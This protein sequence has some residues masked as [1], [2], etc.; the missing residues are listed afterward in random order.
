MQEKH[1]RYTKDYSSR[2]R[3]KN[4]NRHLISAD[5]AEML[6]FNIR[7]SSRSNPLRIYVS[8]GTYNSTEISNINFHSMKTS[9]YQTPNTTGQVTFGGGDV[10]VITNIPLIQFDDASTTFDSSIALIDSSFV[11]VGD[12]IDLLLILSGSIVIRFVEPEPLFTYCL[13]EGSKFNKSQYRLSNFGWV[14]KGLPTRE[15]Q[16]LPAWSISII[17]VGG[18]LLI[19]LSIVLII[20]FK[21]K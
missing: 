11:S 20:K 17:V 6:L 8:P 13:F 7:S 12:S 9:L 1:K 4:I 15:T 5:S 10:D 2:R 3:E 14:I 19:V 16:N 18:V 21:K